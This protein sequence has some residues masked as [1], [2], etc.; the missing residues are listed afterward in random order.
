[1][2]RVEHEDLE[3]DPTNGLMYV[4]GIPFTGMAYAIHPNGSAE[5]EAEYRDGLKCGVSREWYRG[6]QLA[7]EGTLR[8]GGLHGVER[9]WH[10]NG[11]LSSE[12]FGEYGILVKRQRWNEQGKLLEEYE[13]LEDSPDWRMIRELRKK[14][15]DAT[16]HK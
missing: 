16:D 8:N 10:V 9:H 14:Y 6:G 15:G 12:S 1:M 5:Y 11:V 13:L 7:F 4:D 3:Y 2:V